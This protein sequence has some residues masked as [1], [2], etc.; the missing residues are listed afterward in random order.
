MRGKSLDSV[1]AHPKGSIPIP[2]VGA[3][4]VFTHKAPR[5]R[6]KAVIKASSNS[7]LFN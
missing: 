5:C 1:T 6:T 7:R 3:E 4:N 2:P